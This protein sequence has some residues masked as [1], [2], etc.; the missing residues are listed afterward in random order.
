MGGIGANDF[1]TGRRFHVC[2]IAWRAADTVDSVRL[3]RG[4]ISLG[5]DSKSRTAPG[6]N[7]R[8]RLASRR[9]LG[10]S[11]RIAFDRFSV[12]LD[13]GDVGVAARAMTASGAEI[14]KADGVDLA[15]IH[16]VQQG[17]LGPHGG[18]IE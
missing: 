3:S 12:N 5:V 10:R 15:Q 16:L 4:S 14:G 11:R 2:G 9:L 18:R 1:S 7:S 17:S 13:P 8:R 6:S